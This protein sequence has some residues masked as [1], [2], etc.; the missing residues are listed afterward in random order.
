MAVT[1]VEVLIGEHKQ[2]R[3]SASLSKVLIDVPTYS[4]KST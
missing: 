1:V 2:H 3:F 4:D